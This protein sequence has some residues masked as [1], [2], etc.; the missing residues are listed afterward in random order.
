MEGIVL[1]LDAAEP[2]LAAAVPEPAL[3]EG[4]ATEVSE[5][6]GPMK[7]LRKEFAEN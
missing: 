4:W 5:S 6:S 1:V 7:H 2:M 3:P